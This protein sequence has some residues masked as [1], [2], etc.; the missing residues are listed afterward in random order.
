MKL[1]Q[2]LLILASVVCVSDLS[3]RDVQREGKPAE[4]CHL[5]YGWT[6]WPPYMHTSKSGPAGVQVQLVRWIARKMGCQL[7]F[8]KMKWAESLNDIKSGK[9]DIVGRAS[10]TQERK[11]YAYFSDT[12]RE[13]LLVLTVR[14]GEA[15]NYKT[16]SLRQLIE[17]GFRLGCLRD[18]Y[19]G[20]EI[21][22]LRK[23]KR[24]ST[25]IVSFDKEIDILSAL[26]KREIDGF[27]EAPFTIDN[28][29]MKRQ[30][31]Y[32]FEEHPL[33]V[34]V[35]DLHFMFSRQSVSEE[36]VSEFNLA[37]AEVKKSVRYKN[38]WFWSSIK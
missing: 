6:D 20:E 3:A 31:N 9:I 29:S 36:T 22:S 4:N 25:Q 5:T 27:F 16:S 32:Q 14:K 8:R 18:G 35:G 10:I 13:D 15:K 21:E 24:F 30:S 1:K 28:V 17:S 37:L 33:E 11:S 2:L 23:D 34:I 26:H 12:Y 38:H 19:I 7:S